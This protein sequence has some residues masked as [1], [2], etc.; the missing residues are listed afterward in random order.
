MIRSQRGRIIPLGGAVRP[1][2]PAQPTRT[3]SR[4]LPLMLVLPLFAQIFHYMID[5]GPIYYLSKAWPF[6]MLP[7][8][9]Y[10]AVFHKSRLALPYV[11]ALIYV[12]AVTPVLSMLWLGNSVVDALAN[13]VKVWPLT[14]YFSLLALL[15]LLTPSADD[16]VK[17]LLRLGFGTLLIMWLLWVI[18][19]ASAYTG[20]P[21]QSKLFLFEYERGNRIYFPMGFAILAMFYAMQSLLIRPRF[22]QFLLIGAVIL[23]MLVIFKQRTPMG[24]ASLVMV[25]MLVLRLPKLW[26]SGVLSALLL[27]G[28]GGLYVA[29][30]RF[31]EIAQNFGASLTIRQNSM[32]LLENYLSADPL[33]WIFGSGG[34]SR[35]GKINM[36]EI[37]GRKDF[38]LA[39]LGWAGIIFEFGVVGALLLLLLYLSALRTGARLPVPADPRHRA[40]LGALIGNIAFLGLSTAVYSAVFTPGELAAST[41][42]MLYLSEKSS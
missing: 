6:L 34:A 22:W 14:Y 39:D 11:N 32:A 13:S 18:V 42:L 15:A 35:L 2:A 41:A 27:A 20:D 38:F 31:G 17:A 16:L 19:P 9:A 7:F 25:G 29:I 5:V 36:A 4:V 28:L 21:A 26:R 33:R 10:G 3:A 37:I 40:M 1:V 23:T 24:A 8:A 12:L 30:A